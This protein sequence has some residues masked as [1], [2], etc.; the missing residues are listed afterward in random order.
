MPLWR[1]RYAVRLHI[2]CRGDLSFKP[3]DEHAFNPRSIN[4]H[5][6]PARR[7]ISPQ[8]DIRY[9][10]ALKPSMTYQSGIVVW[11]GLWAVY[12]QD[13]S[14]ANL[15][16]VG[17]LGAIG[18]GVGPGRACAGQATAPPQGFTLGRAPASHRVDV[19]LTGGGGFWT[20]PCD[21]DGL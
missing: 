4:V 8:M 7:V 17:T 3:R 10:Q 5:I 18:A 1:G 2:A 11:V 12:G 20:N 21:L 14:A 9:G 16:G 19:A 13:V 15:S 6:E